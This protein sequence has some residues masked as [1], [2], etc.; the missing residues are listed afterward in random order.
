VA[1]VHAPDTLGIAGPFTVTAAAYDR[2]RGLVAIVSP[3]AEH[4]LRVRVVGPSGYVR[5]LEAAPCGGAS[6]PER[7]TLSPGDSIVATL[8]GADLGLGA[9]GALRLEASYVA[10]A[11]Q[12]PVVERPLVVRNAPTCPS[13]DYGIHFALGVAVRDA[14][15]DAWLPAT[16]VATD[17]SFREV[18]GPGPGVPG[19]AAPP[20]YYGVAE[21]TGTYQVTVNAAGYKSWTQQN[22]VVTRGTDCHVRTAS[23]VARLDPS[24]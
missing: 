3:C 15:T 18:L 14:V 17:G 23:L 16:V 22:V 20:S 6:A 21:R 8:A 5:D 7:T 9:S 2:T 10:T 1:F 19:V 11:G 12:S 4:G 24:S 13:N